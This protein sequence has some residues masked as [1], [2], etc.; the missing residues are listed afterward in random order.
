[1]R[2]RRTDRRAG[3]EGPELSTL[4]LGCNNFGMLTDADQSAAVVR[5]ALEVGVTHFDAAEMYGEGKS[6]EFLGAALGSRRD[7]VVVATKFRPRGDG[8]FRS[9]DLA[10]RITEAAEQSLRRLSLDA[11]TGGGSKLFEVPPTVIQ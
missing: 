6:E 5:A 4:G 8:T 1:M 2:G 3:S 9:G 11:R 10:R 7:E